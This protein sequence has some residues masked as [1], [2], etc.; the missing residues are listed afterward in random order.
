MRAWMQLF[1]FKHRP[2]WMIRSVRQVMI[3]GRGIVWIGR[4]V[5]GFRFL[6]EQ[7]VW[8]V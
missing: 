8:P 7:L 5:G 6:E 3:C 4:Q 2:E 1:M